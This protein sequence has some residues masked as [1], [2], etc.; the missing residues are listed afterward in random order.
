MVLT[1]FGREISETELRKQCDCNFLGT[2]A[3][4]VVDAARQLGFLKTLKCTLSV[5]ELIAQINSGIYPIVYVDLQPIDGC[6]D[7]H[8][9]VVVAV[10]ESIVVVYDPLQGERKLPRLVF[11][12]AWQIKSNLSILIQT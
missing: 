9:M 12:K 5:E 10:E 7:S 2:E 4:K 6:K 11:E 1:S 3:L 8:A